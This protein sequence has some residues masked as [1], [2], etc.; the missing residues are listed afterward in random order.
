MGLTP[1]E[2]MYGVPAPIVPNLQS[3][4]VAELENDELITKFRAIQW[5]YKYIWPKLHVLYEAGP[6][7]EPHRFQP[8]NW[9]YVKRVFRN[10]LEPRWKGPF[11]VLLTML[12][13]IKVDGITTWVYSAHTR[14]TDLLF[15][16]STVTGMESSEGHQSSQVKIDTVL[17]L[18][19]LLTV[20]IASLNPHQSFDLT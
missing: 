8:G 1:F 12:T 7:P 5:A 16:D 17:S 6:L 15:P 13:A 11:V 3:T 4:T 9:V 2:I 10:V 18:L 14:P 19:F 20:C